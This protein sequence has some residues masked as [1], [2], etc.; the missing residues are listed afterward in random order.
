MKK[1]L[2]SFLLSLA[3]GMGLSAQNVVSGTVIDKEGNPIPGAKIEVVG[4]AEFTITE[5]D[6]TFRLETQN[7][8]KKVKAQYVG[9]NSKTQTVVPNMLIKLTNSHIGWNVNIGF[10]GANITGEDLEDNSMIP[11]YKL[12]VGVEIP[13]G[14][15]WWLMPSLEYKLKGTK[16]EDKGSDYSEKENIDLHYLQVPIMGAY[17]LN[18]KNDMD[19][20][21]KAGIYVAYALKGKGKYEEIYDG[22]TE[23]ETYN[24]FEEDVIKRFDSGVATGIDFGYKRFTVGL[25]LNFSFINL[26]EDNED[27]LSIYNGAMFF[28]VGYRF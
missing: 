3:G 5:L 12:G 21:F 7:P 28:S 16:F 15:N 9:L 2:L 20:T 22:R 6:G 18:F 10:G 8:A 19:L 25:D 24:L 23:K 27:D 13:L 4:S 1:L 11:A 17:R 26:L 14:R